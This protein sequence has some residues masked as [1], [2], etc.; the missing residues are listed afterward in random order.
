MDTND[1]LKKEMASYVETLKRKNIVTQ[2][3]VTYNNWDNIKSLV[4]EESNDTRYNQF[5][6]EDI[7]P[8]PYIDKSNKNGRGGRKKSKKHRKKS[9]K[10]RKSRMGRFPHKKSRNKRR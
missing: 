10:S 1:I 9:R 3:N 8:N 4:Q 5:T 7:Y 6:Y 2:K